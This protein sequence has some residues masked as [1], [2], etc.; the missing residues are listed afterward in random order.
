MCLSALWWTEKSVN[1]LSDLQGMYWQKA[2][3]VSHK[4]GF[5]FSV[6]GNVQHVNYFVYHLKV[7][8]CSCFTLNVLLWGKK[9]KL[10]QVVVVFFIT[11]ADGPATYTNCNSVKFK[12]FIFQKTDVGK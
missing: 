6:F 10:N 3:C 1:T 7:I 2:D 9:T 11:Q 4:I 5:M 8:K 12:Q